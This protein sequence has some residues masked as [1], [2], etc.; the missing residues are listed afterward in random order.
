[1]VER[2]EHW[3]NRRY[4]VNRRDIYLLRTPTG[5]QVV[6][7]VGGADGREVT[8]YFDDEAMAHRMVEA[9]RDDV[10]EQLSNWALMPQRSTR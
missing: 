8:H 2:I 9:M 5:W 4:G 6:G 1:M 7:R 10:P 3:F